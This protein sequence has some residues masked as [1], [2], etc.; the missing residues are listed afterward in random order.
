MNIFSSLAIPSFDTPYRTAPLH[1]PMPFW[2]QWMTDSL[3]ATALLMAAVLIFR[4]LTLAGGVP[5]GIYESALQY[6]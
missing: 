1:H 5:H 2:Q 6:R 4:S 3:W